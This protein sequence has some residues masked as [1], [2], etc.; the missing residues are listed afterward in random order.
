M[1]SASNNAIHNTH[2]AYKV[3]L[4]LLINGK[5]VPVV[6][7]VIEFVLN[8][9]PIA[10]VVIP[11]GATFNNKSAG[12]V[13]GNEILSPDDLK[14]KKKVQLVLNGQGK[15][16]PS[17]SKATPKGDYSDT[18]FEGYVLSST[19]DFSTTGVATTVVLAH[20]MYDL[21]SASFSSGDFDKTAPDDWFSLEEYTLTQPSNTVVVRRGPGSNDV[22][23]NTEY[24]DKDWWEGIIK[25]AAVY[26]AG[27]P[28]RHF[29]NNTAPSNNQA[30]ITAINRLVSKGKLTLN[31]TAKA[32]L[33]SCPLVQNSINTMIGYTIFTG[34]GGSTA[35]EKFVSLLSGFG[36]VLAPRVDEV[37]VMTYNP[38]A[39][40]DVYIPD[41]ECDFG[42]SSSN[43]AQLPV[44]AIMYG[45]GLPTEL[46]TLDRSKVESSFVGSF[47]AQNLVGSVDAGPFMVFPT[48]DYLNTVKA[49]QVANG[50]FNSRV[51]IIPVS[52]PT[53]GKA[54][55]TQV[56]L[57]TNFAN[58][59]AKAYYYSKVFAAKTQDVICGFRLDVAPGD[60]IK[61]FQSPN[62]VSGANVSGLAKNWIKRGIVEAVTHTL[63]A[64]GNRINTTYRL[65]HVMEAQDIDMF[66][67]SDQGQPAALFLNKPSNSAS[68]LKVV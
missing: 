65:R 59:V 64:P 49:A 43:P 41:S 20:W 9:I 26:K 56:L 35:F 42:G 12:A 1:P 54:T 10:R 33:A 23:A 16:H 24:L 28:L 18:I 61:I 15:P 17:G 3:H 21:D 6:E 47:T 40:V 19:A 29:V 7:A 66:Q 62:S 5:T 8:Q 57:P 34:Q 14:G 13:P 48:P 67:V 58:E 31:S 53:Q 4:S 25:P 68:P 22:V 60:C 11:S 44:G 52:N 37:L 51:G 36:A 45:G 30:A 38:L 55:S 32:A 27:L 46:A 2:A 63:S 39:P 50:Q